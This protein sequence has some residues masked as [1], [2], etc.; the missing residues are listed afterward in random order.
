MKTLLVAVLGLLWI[1]VAG[2]TQ[3]SAQ[4]QMVLIDEA[5][6]GIGVG[7]VTATETRYGT[8]FQ[9][10]LTNLLPGLH[11]FHVHENPACGPGKKDGQPEAGLAAG[12]HY[13]PQKTGKHAGPYGDGHLGDLP[14]LFVN[15]KAE[16][17]HPVLA[18]R[19]KLADLKG[20]ALV[21]HEGSDNYTE[22]PKLGGGG[23]R[24]A[25]GVVQ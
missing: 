19:I 24:M 23:G 6:V 15:D 7:T 2:H 25:C 3:Q 9:P 11:G 4:V 16:A 18:P 1:P 5:G 8:L 20:R 22:Q 10:K 12:G 14:A 17:Y 21:I 13:D